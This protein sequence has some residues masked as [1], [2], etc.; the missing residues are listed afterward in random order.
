MWN[1]NPRTVLRLAA[2]QDRIFFRPAPYFLVAAT[3]RELGNWARESAAHE[4]ELATKLENGVD[5]LMD[6]ALQHC[7]LTL[8]RIRQLYEMRFS[9]VNPIYDIIDKCVGSQ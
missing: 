8:E 1:P 6:L 3:A 7:G 4:H 9:I 5:V 2:A